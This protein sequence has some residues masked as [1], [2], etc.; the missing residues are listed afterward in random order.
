MKGRYIRISTAAQNTARQ[1]AQS[2]TEEL[3]FIDKISG[4]VPFNNRPQAKE[5]LRSITENKINFVSVASIDR[6][7]R[8]TLDVL[9]T[10][11]LLHSKN[12][13]IFVENIGLHSLTDGKE[14]QVFKL[15]CS[16]MSNIAEM[17]R[18]VILERINEGIAVAKLKG[19]YKGRIKG[20]TE[21][22]TE[23]LA[24]YP[25]VVSMLK[26]QNKP[27]LREIAKLCDVTVNTVQKIKRML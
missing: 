7:G 3:L 2:K 23:F 22:Q 21:T 12:V 5:L 11:Q 9:T 8:N 6:L 24:K 16:V 17:E 27:S 13:T 18:T 4:S 19:I 14:N 15:I 10:I 25:K 1:E 26:R 20:T